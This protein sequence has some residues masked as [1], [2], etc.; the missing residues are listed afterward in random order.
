METAP[1]ATKT[2]GFLAVSSL[3]SHTFLAGQANHQEVSSGV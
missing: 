2:M 1:L 3:I